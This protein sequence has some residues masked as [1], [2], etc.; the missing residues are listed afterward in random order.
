LFSDCSTLPHSRYPS[1]SRRRLRIGAVSYLNSQPL[2]DSLAQHFHD[3]EVTYD[4]P[5]RLADHLATGQLDVG[6]IP[7]IEWIRNPTYV[8]VSNACIGCRGPVLSV[9]LLSRVPIARIRTLA[10]DAGSRTSAALVQILLQER[11]GLRPECLALPLDC[12]PHSSDADAILLIGD[13]AIS[14][15]EG[16][17]VETWDLGQQWWDWSGL[18]FVFAVWAARPGVPV[19]A[20]ASGLA[21]V[22]DEGLA[23]LE[24]IVAKHAGRAGLSRHQALCYLRDNLHFYFGAEQ[25][26]GLHLFARYAADFLTPISRDAVLP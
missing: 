14:P 19:A 17:Y 10:L 24:R 7:S 4:V 23:N 15:E 5:S 21:A 12:A 25:Q 2:V 6:L 22:R 11:F 1:I 8:R 13:R 9:K 26:Q 20:L 18:P 3:W 16:E